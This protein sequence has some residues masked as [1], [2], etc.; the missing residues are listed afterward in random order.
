[1]MQAITGYVREAAPEKTAPK[2]AAVATCRGA[3]LRLGLLLLLLLLGTA[4]AAGTAGGGSP[5]L[6]DAAFGSAG[7][8]AA[9]E[10]F[11]PPDPNAAVGAA[12]DAAAGGAPLDAPPI[13]PSEAADLVPVA[14]KVAE[15]AGANASRALRHGTPAGADASPVVELSIGANTTSAA[16]LCTGLSTKLPPAQ[17][18][19]WGD[20]YGSLNGDSWPYCQGTK[21]DPCSCKG[22]NGDFP[23][24][25]GDGTTVVKMYAAP[26]AL[27]SHVPLSPVHTH[28]HRS[29]F[30]VLP[31]GAAHTQHIAGSQR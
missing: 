30:C 7:A 2:K 27:A 24:C 21:T 22:Q 6:A 4:A 15:S 16:T 18:N 13:A 1:M 23:V 20:F 12:V 5:Q 31:L 8:R 25:N 14:V 28:S 11:D 9:A 26:L 19:A 3:Q 10:I 17:C 29:P